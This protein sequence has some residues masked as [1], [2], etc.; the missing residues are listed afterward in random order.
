MIV[1]IPVLF[2]HAVYGAAVIYKCAWSDLMTFW[3]KVKQ[4]FFNEQNDDNDDDKIV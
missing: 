2:T 3:Q 1:M 4:D